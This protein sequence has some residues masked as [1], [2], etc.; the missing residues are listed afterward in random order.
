MDDLSERSDQE[1]LS[2]V[3]RL[4]GSQR[5]LTAKLVAHLAEI[6]ERRL[7]LLAGFSSMF[8][9]CQKKFGMGE[10]EAFR[11]IL[12]ARLGRRFP[13]VYSL[14]GSGS[15]NLSTLELL[16]EWL[17]EENHEELF[18][19]VAGKAKRE[20]QALLSARFPRPERPSRISRQA[21]I[22][23][24]SETRYRVEFTASDELR[25]K[26]ELCRDLMS[27]ANPSRDLGVVIERAVDFLLVELER[28]RLGRVKRPRSEPNDRT[29]GPRPARVP[30]AVRREVF[31]RDG[32]R[33]TYVADDGRRCK[34]RAFLELD[35]V[36]PKAL[37]GS[38]DV[39]NLRVRC[40][41]H[42]QLWA[43]QAFGRERVERGRRLRQRK[44]TGERDDEQAFGREQVERGR[45]FCQK[46]STSGRSEE[47]GNMAV[48]PLHQEAGDR[49]KTILEK[50]RLA[51]RNMGFRDDQA[52]R[53]I[54][55]V[56]RMREANEPLT[57]EQALRDALL[58]ATAA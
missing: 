1:L 36:E 25:Q 18:A 13:V 3:A 23:P 35:H 55:A 44:S 26:L 5:A 4:I 2:S 52:W 58:V 27:H 54:L 47:P 31:G 45:H 32:T 21:S 39:P 57:T 17:T 8:D 29:E 10:G 33:C 12:A 49:T 34:A 19:A 22:E 11:R 50:V 37:G 28:K 53:A 38:N 20:V 41:A 56:V 42:N 16:R 24:L 43:E 51:L 40:R 30:N 14:L 48:G 9:F 7:H 15:V 6:E 46:K